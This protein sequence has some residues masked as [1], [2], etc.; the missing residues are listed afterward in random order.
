MAAAAI[1][2]TGCL[3]TFLVLQMDEFRPK[4]GDI[5]AFRPGSQDGDTWQMTVPAKMVD[6]TGRV[7]RSCT[8][9]P[10]V[11]AAHGGSLVVEGRQDEP[12]TQYRIHW[13]GGQTDNAADCGTG[14]DLQV[15]RM[16]L[17]RL[18]NAAGGFGVGE[19]GIH[20]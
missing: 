5:V 17:Q 19:K 10:N 2:V 11:M 14:V 3:S 6:L 20:N 13:A 16:D 9:D 18:A 7:D 4:V 1:M 8:L 15:S 12:G